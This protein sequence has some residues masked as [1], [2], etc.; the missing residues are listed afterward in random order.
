MIKVHRFDAVW[1]VLECEDEG[2]LQ[3]LNEYFTFEVPNF[4]FMQ[5]RKDPSTGK[6][7][8]A[9]QGW[10][11][12][13]RLFH[14]RTRKF[15]QG[16]RHRLAEF[17]KER[18]LTL[19]FPESKVQTS[20]EIMQST[21]NLVQRLSLPVS[22]R[23]Y[24]YRALLSSIKYQRR[25]ILSP[26]GSGKSLIIYMLIRYYLE[27]SKEKIL[28]LVPTINLVSQMHNDFIEYGW[29]GNDVHRI[30]EGQEKTSDKPVYISTWQSIYDMPREYFKQFKVI[31]CDE[32]HGAT[33]KS[34]KH[35]MESLVAADIRI[36]LSG[37]LHD[38]PIHRLVLEGLFGPIEEVAKT[39]ELVDKG[40]LAR[41][42]IKNF[43]FGYP[44][45]IRKAMKKQDYQSEI[46][47]IT[48]YVC[49]NRFIEDLA[50]TCK[51]P[52]L[53]L[54]RLIDH[55]KLLHYGIGYNGKRK[56]HLI[57]GATPADDREDIRK[58]LDSDP[59][60]ILVA[61]YGT[62][63]VG[64]NIPG[65]RHIIFASPYKSKVKVLQSIGRGTRIANGKDSFTVYDLTDD[66]SIGDHQNHTLKHS[67]ERTKYY[68]E[69]GFDYRFYNM[70]FK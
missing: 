45:D 26:T 47:F 50:R 19:L 18:D 14:V 70:E 63:S 27:Q 60:S 41:P 3:D 31:L 37:T 33:A 1:D 7:V 44:K 68:A 39:M 11:G 49:R 25:I 62:F 21:A 23:D 64:A 2:I 9:R 12:K 10:D 22:P 6:R 35:I 69:E 28:V 67:V 56:A 61:S 58:I 24:Q 30:Y 51:G 42:I 17:A 54:F 5:W 46:D 59:N 13:I 4:K 48:N 32:V 15:P 57:Y 38:L 16:L 20:R 53:V 52:T 8:R 65:I 43:I 29:S 40:Q 66:L 55:G 34:I 36:G